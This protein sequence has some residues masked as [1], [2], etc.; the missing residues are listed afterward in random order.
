MKSLLK[1]I[2]VSILVCVIIVMLQT[3][4]N[5]FK[6]ENLTDPDFLGIY[7]FYSFILTIINSL[8]YSYFKRKV[9]WGDA[10]WKRVLLAALGA[11][12]LT[13]IGFFFCRMIHL[14]VFED[15]P[16]QEFIANESI[17]FYFFPFLFTTI[18]SLFLHLVYFYKALQDKK[19][20]EQ[21]IIAG[22]AS[23]QF[24]A[25]K[26]QLDPHFLFNSLNVLSALIDENPDQ[27]QKF[28]SSLSKVYRYVL[29]QKNK[30]LVSLEEELKFA[31]T[32][33]NLLKMRFEDG[34]IFRFPEKLE[35]PEAKVV[36]LSLQLLLEN[37]VKHNVVNP[38]DPLLIE[39]YEENG[40]LVVKNKLQPKE[41]LN[42]GHGV[43]LRN[44]IERYRLLTDRKMDVM[45]TKDEFIVRLPLL[46][47][48]SIT[49]P[50]KLKFEEK[51]SY[52][53]AREQVKKEKKFYGS[54]AAYCI[55]IPVLAVFNYLSSDQLW[56]I[57]PAIGWGLGLA[58]QAMAVF[59]YNPFLGKDWEERKIKE[60]MDKQP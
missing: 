6:F 50:S 51:D 32:Y 36:P 2:R 10:N 9:G 12:A 59:N 26:N 18:I 4:F 48:L 5:G 39:I 7:F 31:K 38:V 17:D 22:T 21:K 15:V 19:V 44:I 30:E 13:L 43:G 1:I 47:K 46:T 23:A 42:S 49:M 35:N 60:F 53:R 58:F 57:F 11:V 14:T 45:K 54:L 16:F 41:I 29:E 33:I 25:L 28:T 20:K 55:I 40:M 37:T 34:I 27:A 52:I 24:D 3:I 8:Y 56:V